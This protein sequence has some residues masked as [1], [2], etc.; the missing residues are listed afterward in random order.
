MPLYV[1]TSAMKTRTL[2]YMRDLPTNTTIKL[3]NFTTSCALEL[4]YQ[5]K[6]HSLLIRTISE[7]L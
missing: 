5:I 3:T 2:V 4:L 1:E 6:T 7:R